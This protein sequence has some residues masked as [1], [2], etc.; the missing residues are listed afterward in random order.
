MAKADWVNVACYITVHNLKWVRDM[1]VGL[2]NMT[3]FTV[4]DWAQVVLFVLHPSDMGNCKHH[5]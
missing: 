1:P 5:G 4:L 3:D 2:G